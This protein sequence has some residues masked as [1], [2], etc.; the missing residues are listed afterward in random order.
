M[1]NVLTNS[2][3]IEG[4]ILWLIIEIDLVIYAKSEKWPSKIKKTHSH[5]I[6]WY[7]YYFLPCNIVEIQ[8]S[9]LE[10]ELFHDFLSGMFS[11]L[12]YDF[13]QKKL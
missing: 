12:K 7:P 6:N 5:P 4:K 11:T 1:F 8:K 9:Y 3:F 13:T 2:I 10:V